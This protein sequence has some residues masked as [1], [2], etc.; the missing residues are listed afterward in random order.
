MCVTTGARVSYI[1]VPEKWN[2]YILAFEATL[3]YWYIIGIDFRRIQ[4]LVD[5]NHIAQ[6][7]YH[8]FFCDKYY[9]IFYKMDW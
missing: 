5:N 2:A 3:I 4:L 7:K 9:K 1:N 6:K 8:Y